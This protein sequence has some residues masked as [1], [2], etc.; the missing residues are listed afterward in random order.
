MIIT[1]IILF[2]FLKKTQILFP[3]G[4][5]GRHEETNGEPSKGLES[6]LTAEKEYY[7]TKASTMKKKKLAYNKDMSKKKPIEG[8]DIGSIPIEDAYYQRKVK[9]KP[10]TSKTKRSRKSKKITTYLCPNCGGKEL[11][12][13]AG[14]ITG[15]KY[16]CKDCDYIGSFIIEKDF[17]I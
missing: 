3:M 16:H 5:K 13:E 2:Y 1:I 8:P 6:I 15:Y 11:F 9:L 14:F 4:E 17:K 10:E 7:D 12:Y